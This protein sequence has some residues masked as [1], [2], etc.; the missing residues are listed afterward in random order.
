[1]SVNTIALTPVDENQIKE[2]LSAGAITPGHLVELNS[3]GDV[4]VHNTAGAPSRKLFALENVATAKG[5]SDAYV[6]N[7]T[8][9]YLEGNSGDVVYGWLI[10][11]TGQDVT[12]NATR[13]VSNGDGT[14]Q[15]ADGAELDTEVVG[16]AGESIDNDPGSAAV[17]I[18]VIVA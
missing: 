12:A 16:V 8:T 4:I 14:L 13:L 11:G 15:A 10:N 6:D 17:R 7:E 3:A 9:R 18:R 5:I 1:M 2:A